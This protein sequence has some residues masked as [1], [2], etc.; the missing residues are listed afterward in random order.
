MVVGGDQGNLALPYVQSARKGPHER[1][2]RRIAW[3]NFEAKYDDVGER[4]Y[5]LMLKYRNKK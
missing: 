1:L 2:D 3:T 5:E 4:T